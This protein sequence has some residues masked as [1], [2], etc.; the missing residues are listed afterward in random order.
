MG[1]KSIAREYANSIYAV[2]GEGKI[3][4]MVEEAKFFSSVL[5]ALPEM[6]KVFSNPAIS[7]D[8]KERLAALLG[9]K[10]GFDKDFAGF[11]QLVVGKRR[12]PIWPEIVEA[13]SELSDESEGI[14]RGKV[15]SAKPLSQKQKES[16]E[17]DIA[18]QLH[19]NV[20]LEPF[21]APELLG[22]CEVRIGSL[23]YDGTLRRALE[24]IRTS[25]LKR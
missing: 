25:L 1:K 10:A 23:V 7:N 15:Y 4:R 22:G 21:V 13:L 17:A 14:V 24:D 12:I 6:A 11:I 8:A 2:A 9:E 20:R 3:K 19:K 16:L 18:G 5:E